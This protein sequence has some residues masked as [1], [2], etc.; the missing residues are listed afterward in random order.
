MTKIIDAKCPSISLPTYKIVNRKIT[1]KPYKYNQNKKE[2]Y[3]N[4]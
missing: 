1:T 4:L 2:K 3:G